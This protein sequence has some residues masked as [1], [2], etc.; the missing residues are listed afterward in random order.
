MSTASSNSALRQSTWI[1]TADAVGAR[2]LRCGLTPMHRVHLDL[3][4]QFT[5]DEG[6]LQHTRPSPRTGRTGHSG[7]NHESDEFLARS[8]RHLG[9]WLSKQDSS[10]QFTYVH[11]FAPPRMVGALRK[12]MPA[13]LTDRTELH[14]A[15]LTPFTPAALACHASVRRLLRAPGDRSNGTSAKA[16]A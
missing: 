9:S 11:I 5:H 14:E 8:A 12:V 1:I 3:I 2:L 6:Q 15:D 7:D 13:P 4:D 16:S 10:H